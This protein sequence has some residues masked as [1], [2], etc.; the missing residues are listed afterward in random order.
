MS[1]LD[2]NSY[3]LT[4]TGT[5]YYNMIKI[6]PN[7]AGIDA[8]SW[9]VKVPRRGAISMVDYRTPVPGGPSPCTD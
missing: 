2:L 8:H 6:E 1:T 3:R 4:G 5:L 9:L 7:P